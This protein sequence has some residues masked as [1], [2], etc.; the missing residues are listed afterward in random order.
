M[1]RKWRLN[2][3]NRKPDRR[4]KKTEAAIKGAVLSL[5]A[6][7]DANKITIQDIADKADIN[8][9]T[10]YLHY[11]DVYDALDKIENE[12]IAKINELISNYPIEMLVKSPY[13]FLQS[14]TAPLYEDI[15]LIKKLSK[16]KYWAIFINKA[17]VVI[18][19]KYIQNN[20]VMNAFTKD[21][22]YRYC[23]SF[24]ISGTAGFIADWINDGMKEPLSEVNKAIGK[25]IKSGLNSFKTE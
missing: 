8:R 12:S 2:M 22:K 1:M 15:E 14:L 11:Y 25:L 17:K 23:L 6:E 9:A 18:E 24:I 3:K 19:E 13:D 21:P 16:S 10:F 4:T 7:K 20:L 5:I